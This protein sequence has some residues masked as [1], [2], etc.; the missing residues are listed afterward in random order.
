MSENSV[1]SVFE[2][3]E[4]IDLIELFFVLWRKIWVILAC[5]LAG[6]A[7]ALLCTIFL[8][9]PLYQSSSMIY[10]FSKT[11]TLTSAIDL[12]L[13]KQLTV[14]F[15][16]LGKS[17]PVLE[18]VISDLK[19][20]TDYESLLKTIT[21]ENPTD[22]RILKITVK[23]QDPQLACD[24]ANSMAENLAARVAEVTNTDKPSSVEEAVTSPN[25]VSPSKVKNTVLGGACGCIFA[26][27]V[28]LVFYFSDMSVNNEDDV[29][30]YLGLGTLAA[31]PYEKSISEGHESKS[32]KKKKEKKRKT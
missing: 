28:I 12:Q 20:D 17:R 8:I 25:P 13:G 29:R 30:K 26:I 16:I 2:E 14:D 1:V 22:S 10:I 23:N 3:E 4:D 6:A 27:A 9:K 19:L 31:V 24:I 15:E 32:S 21:V 11:T 5:G 18:K 7:V